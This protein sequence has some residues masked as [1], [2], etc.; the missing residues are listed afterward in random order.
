[1]ASDAT[2]PP[3]F[4]FQG[5]LFRTDEA[6]AYTEGNIDCGVSIG[7]S[8]RRASRRAAGFGRC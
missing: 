6:A 8:R 4:T 2:S 7:S 5:P 1:M 3:A